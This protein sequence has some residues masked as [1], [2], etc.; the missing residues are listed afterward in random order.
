MAK[1]RL[2][3]ASEGSAVIVVD[4]R[5]PEEVAILFPGAIRAALAVG[6]IMDPTT[7]TVVERKTPMDLL[8]SLADGRLYQQCAT[9]AE[10]GGLGVVVVHGSLYPDRDG[11]AVA[12][13]QATRW[14]Y[15]SVQMALLSIQ[16]GGIPVLLVPRQWLRETVLAVFNWAAKPHHRRAVPRADLWDRP[17]PAVQALG[18]LTGNI[19]RAKALLEHFG[20]LEET[21]GQLDRWADVNGVGP[22]TV[23]RARAIW[24]GRKG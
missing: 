12:D 13:G 3:E 18:V 21:M 2:R 6:D 11:H 17:D 20:S 4:S 5:E 19:G 14:N 22:S 15:L 23:E 8:Q 16:S 1:R 24:T 7:G 10:L 9:M